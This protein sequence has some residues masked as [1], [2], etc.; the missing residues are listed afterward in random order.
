M[1]CAAILHSRPVPSV[2]AQKVVSFRRRGSVLKI[3]KIHHHILLRFFAVA[4]VR[5]WEATEPIVVVVVS[6][7]LPAIRTHLWLGRQ[8]FGK[9]GWCNMS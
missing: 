6:H 8:R 4:N 9:L 1:A 7:P 3:F 5:A 2:A